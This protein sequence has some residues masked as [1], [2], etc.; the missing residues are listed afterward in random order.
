MKNSSEENEMADE[1][2]LNV[3]VQQP[4]ATEDDY[5]VTNMNMED[6]NFKFTNTSASQQFASNGME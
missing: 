1:G 4:C 5:L 3:I 2:R 6:E